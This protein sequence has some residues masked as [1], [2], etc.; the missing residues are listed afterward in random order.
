VFLI[1]D[2]FVGTV[3]PNPIDDFIGNS[4]LDAWNAV[5]GLFRS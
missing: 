4:L 5:I 1:F 2:Y 3:W